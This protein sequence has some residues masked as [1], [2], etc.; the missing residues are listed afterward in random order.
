[1]KEGK[2]YDGRFD[3]CRIALPCRYG[4][5]R[6]FVPGKWR[7]PK[8]RM[9]EPTESQWEQKLWTLS[10]RGADRLVREN[11]VERENR[12]Q[13]ARALF[14]VLWEIREGKG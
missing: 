8:K 10:R 3:F 4:S 6:I 12:E 14:S 9:E 11:L 7:C 13:A 1:M 2:L 5:Q